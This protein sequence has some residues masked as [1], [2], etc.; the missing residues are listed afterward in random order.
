MRQVEILQWAM[1]GVLEEKSQEQE[2]EK[3]IELDG[4]AQELSMLL[5]LAIQKEKKN[6][7][8]SY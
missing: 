4:I 5:A 1:R 8:K 3:R 7:G 6:I 2:I